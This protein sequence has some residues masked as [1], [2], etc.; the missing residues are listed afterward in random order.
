MSWHARVKAL[1]QENALLRGALAESQKRISELERHVQYLEGIIRQLHNENTPSS[2]K[3]EWKKSPDRL[4]K[5]P[6]PLGK[7]VGA[8]GDTRPSPAID[9]E[10]VIRLDDESYYG[11]PQDY[12]TRIVADVAPLSPVRW[13][14]FYL[15]RYADPATGNL[16]TVSHPDCPAA[17]TFG[18]NLRGMIVMLRE[19][20]N[21]SEQ[22]TTQFLQ[23]LYGFDI[24]AGTIEAELARTASALQPQYAA[25]GEAV[26]TALVKHSDETG[27]SVNGE[28]WSVYCMSTEQHTYLFAN[29][30]KRADHIKERLN[31][32]WERVLVVD[33]HSIYDWYHAKQRCWSHATRKETWLLDEKKTQE[34]M[35]LH[36]VVSG[37]YKTAIALL[38]KK[39]PGPEHVWDVLFLRNRFEQ[40]AQY[41][42]H[43]E[44]CH[45]VMSYVHNA[46]NDW[47]TFML[48]PGVPSTNNLNERDIRKHVMK[49]KNCGSFR[50]EH[51]LL[52]HCVLL[53]LLE[54]W[55]KQGKN[56]HK[57]LVD[58]LK[59]HNAMVNWAA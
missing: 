43:D 34:R 9:E 58:A 47:F 48:V 2:M 10:R 29:E 1:E 54:S 53:S 26:N 14:R 23:N 19:R 18:P 21:L 45:K 4:N 42:W 13:T 24:T 35:F 11:L 40:A 3:P 27:Q 38:E 37:T 46:L 57:T 56:D 20:A 59:V 12:V 39:P 44:S 41:T 49:R 50:S 8:P 15:A 33:G 36:E 22:Q 32:D 7:P 28:H 52:N 51:G 5:Q 31:H 55:K 16:I 6:T 17:G 30:K 25:L